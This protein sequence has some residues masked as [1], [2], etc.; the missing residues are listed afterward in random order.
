[1]MLS[2]RSYIHYIIAFSVYLVGVLVY[3]SVL[4]LS[5]DAR[6]CQSYWN[7]SQTCLI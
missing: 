3:L 4:P 5:P 7:V 1:M 6:R 2:R